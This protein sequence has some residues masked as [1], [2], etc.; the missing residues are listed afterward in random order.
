MD[1][2]LVE[3]KSP[4]VLVVPDIQE[5]ERLQANID[6][7]ESTGKP[8]LPIGLHF[9]NRPK[10]VGLLVSTRRFNIPM[11]VWKHVKVFPSEEINIHS[12][13]IEKNV[14]YY[15]DAET[16]TRRRQIRKTVFIVP[17]RDTHL[18]QV[19]EF[20]HKTDWKLCP[21]D[22]PFERRME[23]VGISGRF[24][25][26]KGGAVYHRKEVEMAE[27]AS[28][29]KWFESDTPAPHKGKK[30]ERMDETLERAVEE[31]QT[32]PGRRDVSSQSSALEKLSR[33]RL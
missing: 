30:L 6:E 11:H 23:V 5:G 26:T 20:C 4:R 28:L 14:F 33:G 2:Q 29:M 1:K 15:L 3:Y 25:T 19:K 16:S 12:V 32:S 8:F 21:E 27:K 10:G 24:L 7:C 18:Q 13:Y 22:R 17:K 9:R 31:Q